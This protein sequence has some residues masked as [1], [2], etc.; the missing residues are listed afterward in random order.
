MSDLVT[1]SYL[2]TYS[3]CEGL[4]VLCLEIP[5]IAMWMGRFLQ[6]LQSVEDSS[7]DNSHFHQKKER[8]KKKKKKII[9]KKKKKKKEHMVIFAHFIRSLHIIHV[10]WRHLKFLWLQWRPLMTPTI[11]HIPPVV[12]RM[13]R[14]QGQMMWSKHVWLCMCLFNNYGRKCGLHSTHTISHS[15]ETVAGPALVDWSH[16]PHTTSAVVHEQEVHPGNQNWL[17]ASNFRQSDASESSL[18][19]FGHNVNS[20]FY[21]WGIWMYY[22]I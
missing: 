18:L 16:M 1:A 19:R 2:S 15:Q 22:S 3:Y 6:Q 13:A 9:K 21:V 11:L 4:L 17:S 20:H 14:Y 7:M 8:K 10:E 5:G 12:R